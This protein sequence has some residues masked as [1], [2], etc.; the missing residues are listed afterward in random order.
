[1][2]FLYLIEKQQN[3]KRAANKEISILKDICAQDPQNKYNCIR[4]LGSLEHQGHVCI[5]FEPMLMNLREVV[6]RYGKDVGISIEAVQHYGRKL[7]VALR[8]LKKCSI[9]HADLKPDNI[10][11]NEAKAACKLADFGSASLITENSITPYLV[12]RFYRAPEISTYT[13]CD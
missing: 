10:L 8:H 6:L 4:L 2:L 13:L 5:V 3:R 1:L 7:V 12:S 9:L 11:V